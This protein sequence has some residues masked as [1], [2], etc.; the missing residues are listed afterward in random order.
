MI[1][2]N[3]LNKNSTLWAE[4]RLVKLL[5]V[6]MFLSQL[7]F[8]FLVY[9]AVKYKTVV[10]IPADMKEQVTISKGFPDDNY[11]RMVISDVIQ[12]ALTYSPATARRQFNRLLEYYAPEEF[13]EASEFW[14]NLAGRIEES[15]VSSVFMV[16]DIHLDPPNKTITVKGDRKQYVDNTVMQESRK[17][18]L[19]TFEFRHG[20][21]MIKTL[22]DKGN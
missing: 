6:G 2:K 3:Y 8:G 12:L 19:I 17:T 5:L 16:N 11:T 13:P 14:Y 1:A 10:L 4:N 18:Y 21:F 20:R 7:G 15:R 9:S 22:L